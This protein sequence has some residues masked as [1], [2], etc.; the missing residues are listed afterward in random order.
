MLA[1][2]GALGLFVV[3]FLAATILP[4]SSEAAFVGALYGGMNPFVALSVAS[5]G[6]VLAVMVNYGLGY[7]LREHFDAKLRKS[8]SGLK[9]LHFS[10]QYGSWALWLTP[11]PMVGDPLTIA[12][13]VFRVNFFLFL[14]VVG[15]L[16]AGRYFAL[17]YFLQ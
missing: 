15:S 3:A 9:A 8:R 14:F 1:E 2:Y 6:N 11:F 7:W 5:A 4:F 12:A 17:W 13:G 10:E 16:R